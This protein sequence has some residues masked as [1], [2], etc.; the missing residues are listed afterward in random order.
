MHNLYATLQCESAKVHVFVKF[1][2]LFSTLTHTEPSIKTAKLLTHVFFFSHC[3]AGMYYTQERVWAARWPYKRLDDSQQ[4]PS[5]VSPRV[6]VFI[7]SSTACEQQT[8]RGS[9]FTPHLK[10]TKYP[11]TLLPPGSGILNIKL[12]DSLF[13]S[14]SYVHSQLY[15]WAC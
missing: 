11:S 12:S 5:T 14:K 13:R 7:V 15:L 10:V 4:P 2:L 9:F 8:A 6:I 3:A 1:L